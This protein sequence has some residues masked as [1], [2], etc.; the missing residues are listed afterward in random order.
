[1]MRE[2][3]FAGSPDA[4][5]L[6]SVALTGPSNSRT[7]TVSWRNNANWQ[8][9]NYVVERATN[10]NFTGSVQTLSDRSQLAGTPVSW[11]GVPTT[12]GGVVGKAATSFVDPSTGK[13][14]RTTYYYRVRAESAQGYSQWSNA[15]SVRY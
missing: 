8:L 5:T 7:I 13:V 10:A 14:A 11:Q 2:V 4:P 9:T 1:M 6:N 12:L 3:N 15:R